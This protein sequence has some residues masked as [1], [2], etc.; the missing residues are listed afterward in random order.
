MRLVAAAGHDLRTPLTRMRLRAEFIG[1]AEEPALWLKDIDEL[2]HIA[3][4]AIQLVREETEMAPLE[5]IQVDE[6]VR[7]VVDELQEQNYRIHVIDTDAVCVL[8][9]RVALSR[10]MRNLMI[11]AATHGMRGQVRVTGGQTAQIIITDDGP[12]IPDNLMARVFEPFFRAD[13][14]R[15]QHIPGVGLGLSIS[16][17]IIRRAG[18]EISIDNRPSG[19]LVQIVSLPSAC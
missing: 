8:A 10:A 13:R 18:G 7:H 1:D 19:G 2:G 14:A 6:L 12:G 15:S 4:S 16:R 17:E 9:G 5:A 11:N 3:D